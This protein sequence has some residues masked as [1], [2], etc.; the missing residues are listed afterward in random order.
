M[1]DL[2]DIRRGLQDCLSR[3]HEFCEY[4]GHQDIELLLAVVDAYRRLDEDEYLDWANAGGP[5]ECTH[6]R[7]EGIPCPKCDRALVEASA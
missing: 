4:F 1:S 3:P 2:S 7:A 5:N 6:G